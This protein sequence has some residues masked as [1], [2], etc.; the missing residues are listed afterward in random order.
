MKPTT[1]S[2]L[3]ERLAKLNQ[4][5]PSTLITY[6]GNLNDSVGPGL[7]NG[8]NGCFVEPVYGNDGSSESKLRLIWQAQFGDSTSHEVILEGAELEKY[9]QLMKKQSSS[10]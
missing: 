1:I 4:F 6:N 2:I 8:L 3:Y 10:I 7:M 9:I 5:I